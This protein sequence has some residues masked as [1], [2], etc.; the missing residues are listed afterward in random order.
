MGVFK[1]IRRINA[2]GTLNGFV[3]KIILEVANTPTD[4]TLVN[5]MTNEEIKLC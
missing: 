4:L 1:S 5:F 2:V 3:L